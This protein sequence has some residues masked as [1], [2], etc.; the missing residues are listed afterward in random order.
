MFSAEIC[1]SSTSDRTFCSSREGSVAVEDRA[2][3][4]RA[5]AVVGR[6]TRRRRISL[7]A[8]SQLESSKGDIYLDL[9]KEKA[10]IDLLD[11]TS[12]EARKT[13]SRADIWRS[14]EE[15]TR[16][17]V[18]QAQF[19]SLFFAI[20]F[21]TRVTTCGQR[22]EERAFINPLPSVDDAFVGSL[23]RDY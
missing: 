22:V 14:E 17:T 16:V 8:S 6:R 23:D 5:A 9:R 12:F 2:H 3:E 21:L 4:E 19:F 18:N 1:R 10:M 15:N 7:F 20:F 11:S 13:F